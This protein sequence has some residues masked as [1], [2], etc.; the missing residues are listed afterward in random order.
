M[1]IKIFNQKPWY[2]QYGTNVLFALGA[3]VLIWAGVGARLTTRQDFIIPLEI[4]PL[5]GVEWKLQSKS[6]AKIRITLEGPFETLGALSKDL[7]LDNIH[8]RAK[9]A[10][11]KEKLAGK[12]LKGFVL[13]LSP[14]R[15]VKIPRRFI[16]RLR[17]VACQP[18]FVLVDLSPIVEKEYRA[19]P[20]QEG[21]APPGDYVID[22]LEIENDRVT[23]RGSLD[24]IKSYENNPENQDKDG[25]AVVYTQAIEVGRAVETFKAF[26]R[27]ALP[28]G[29]IS[30]PEKVKVTVHFKRK[31]DTENKTKTFELEVHFLVAPG[32]N[33]GLYYELKRSQKSLKFK[34]KGTKGDLQVFE[35]ALNASNPKKHPYVFIRINEEKKSGPQQGDIE[36]GNHGGLKKLSVRFGDVTDLTYYVKKL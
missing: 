2:L 11:T 22:K 5:D 8:L 3:A 20:K 16:S 14:N 33:K 34:I 35:K 13:D 26:P 36:L 7:H 29:L 15:D 17:A 32:I 31:E 24:A 6:D 23:I 4:Q 27:F 19:L 18:G 21:E 25:A 28:K 30:D 9:L 12:S 1:K 10:I